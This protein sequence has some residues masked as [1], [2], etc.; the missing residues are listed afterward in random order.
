M[1][2]GPLQLVKARRESNANPKASLLAPRRAAIQAIKAATIR[3]NRPTIGNGRGAFKGIE[4]GTGTAP[5]LVVVIVAVEVMVPLAG[6]V[7]LFGLRAQPEDGGTEVQVKATAALKPVSE[8]IVTVVVVLPPDVIVAEV[9]FRDIEKS[10]V[11]GAVPEP[12]R[13]TLCGLPGSTVSVITSVPDLLPVAAGVK[14]TST[15]QVPLAARLAPQVDEAAL[16]KSPALAPEN[17]M[18]LMVKVAAEPLVSVTV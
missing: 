12:V 17:V 18:L 1:G 5:S 15:V 10:G 6:G 7:T 13:V 9:G 16:E 4:K 11:P 3:H 2:G 8:V 14:T